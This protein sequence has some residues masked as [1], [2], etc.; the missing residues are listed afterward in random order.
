MT[1]HDEARLVPPHPLPQ[2]RCAG[3]DRLQPAPPCAV[4]WPAAFRTDLA[5]LARRASGLSPHRVRGDGSAQAWRLTG[6]EAAAGTQGRAL[7]W[8]PRP[9]QCDT[10]HAHPR[11]D[12]RRGA[13]NRAARPQGDGRSPPST[14]HRADARVP[15]YAY[16]RPDRAARRAQRSPPPSVR[17]APLQLDPSPAPRH[18]RRDRGRARPAA[19]L[20][21][22]GARS[23]CR[24]ACRSRASSPS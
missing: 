9:P 12:H 18:R 2:D 17:R 15:V 10:R 5:P 1:Q 7:R 19:Q 14:L 6:V 4:S 8:R 21:R 16:R 22:L 11:T 3:C 13:A 20:R 23:P 24:T